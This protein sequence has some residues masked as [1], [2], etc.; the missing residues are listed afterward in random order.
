MDEDQNL[1]ELGLRYK[2]AGD[3]KYDTATRTIFGIFVVAAVVVAVSIGLLHM[4]ATAWALG[5]VGALTGALVNATIGKIVIDMIRQ[6]RA[7]RPSDNLIRLF[8]VVFFALAS[9]TGPLRTPD[10]R[11]VP[12]YRERR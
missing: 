8:Y 7:R 12:Q 4:T 5:S 2:Q 3:N 10:R 9:P 6:D 11:R 1:L